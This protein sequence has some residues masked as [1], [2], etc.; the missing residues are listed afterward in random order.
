VPIELHALDGAS[1]A[2]VPPGFH[3]M[4]KPCGSVCNL[5]C[6]YCYYLSKKVLYPGSRF[7]MDDGVLE[8]FTRQYIAAQSVPQVVFGW[9]GGEPTL[10]GVDFYRNALECQRRHTPEGIAVSNALQTNGTLLD[11]EWCEFLKEN[12]FLVGI[13]IDGPRE[14]HDRYRVDK[15]GRPTFE[16]VMAGLERLKA[17]DVDF[18]VLACVHAANE[19][20]GLEVYRFLRDEV[21]APHIQFIPIVELDN[22]TGY[23]EGT[24]VTDRSVSPAAY[25]R[26]LIEVFD[27]WARNDVGK[28]FVQLFDVALAAWLGQVPRLCVFSK[29]CGDA[30]VIEHNGDVYSCDHYVEPDY[31]LGNIESTQLIEMVASPV[32]RAFGQ[33]KA[34]LPAQCT[35][36][37]VRFVCN[38]GCPKNRISETTDGESGLNY[39]CSGYRSFFNQIKLGMDYMASQIESRRAPANVMSFLLRLDEGP[40]GAERNQ[41]CPCGSGAKWKNCH[42]G[43]RVRKAASRDGGLDAGVPADSSEL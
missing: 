30:L 10:L 22:E 16:R 13:S 18:N 8:E 23:Q 43:G 34:D 9:Q 6:E 27:E 37:E 3:V 14:L 38:G 41:P 2:E 29:T 20:H 32:Q 21:E 17:H 36:C 11:D 39:L 7:H 42:G 35:E 25:G 15:S 31:L 28:V 1:T 5:A 12:G 33:A 4:A 40:S 19:D 26:F 24:A